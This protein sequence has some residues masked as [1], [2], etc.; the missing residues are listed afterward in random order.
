VHVLAGLR[1]ELARLVRTLDVETMSVADAG[2]AIKEF[3]AIERL[4]A[5]GKLLVT[6]RAAVTA[7][8]L[9]RDTGVSYGQARSTVDAAHA[10]GDSPEVE[11]AV[12][13]GSLSESQ[14]R[15][16]APAAKADPSATKELLDSARNEAF[17]KTKQRCA[18]VRAAAAG[19]DRERDRRIHEN[20]RLRT[21]QDAEGAGHLEIV[22][23]ASVIAR[24]RAALEPHRDA[25]FKEARAAGRVERAETHAFDGFVRWLEAQSAAPS[26]RRRRRNPT[27]EVIVLIDGAA[28]Q[29][30]HTEAGETCE[31]AGL[32]PVSVEEASKVLGDALLSLVIKHG[33]DIRTIVH[34]KRSINEVLQTGLLA[35]GWRCSTPSCPNTRQ[36]ERDHVEAICLGGWTTLE[37]LDLKCRS[38]HQDKTRDDL[39]RLRAR[40]GGAGRGSAAAKASA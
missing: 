19:N 14:A 34:T 4:A 2:E 17:G 40:R 25:A 36:I 39:T 27:A 16:I 11:D 5:A 32:G 12:R 15:E 18:K 30:G 37:Q 26:R 29:R 22:G 13:S 1:S 6:R 33:V 7:E 21:W 9:A 20:R 28:L 10:V 3:A 23:P 31:I 35:R 24:F 38:C 8:Q